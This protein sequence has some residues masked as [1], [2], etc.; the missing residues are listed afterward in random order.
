MAASPLPLLVALVLAAAA[1][2]PAAALEGYGNITNIKLTTADFPCN[3]ASRPP[4][5][6]FR[7]LSSAQTAMCTKKGNGWQMKIV[8]APLANVTGDMMLW[9]FRNLPTESAVSPLDNQTY[10]IYLLMHP[11]DH[12]KHTCPTCAGG[13]A[14]K[15][16]DNVTFAELPLTNCVRTAPNQTHPWVCDSA[17]DANPGV[18]QQNPAS[19]WDK[20]QQT[21]TT[22]RVV[23]LTN[24]KVT[25]WTRGCKTAS[26]PCAWIIK[27]T[28]SWKP[29]TLAGA[30]GLTVT[31][32]TRVGIGIGGPDKTI[33]DGYR[34]GLDAFTVC[35][36]NA[37][38]QVEEYGG[39]AEWLPDAYW[40]A[41]PPS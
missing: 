37:Q 21:G 2:S 39:L 16:G 5:W 29:S 11:R 30:P 4:L 32:D 41:N 12:A 1:I 24:K 10:P 15:A 22:V 25:W 23:A 20:F 8:H 7:L 38:H 6:P 9:L 17:P 40:R 13:R 28:Q 3:T 33:T 18:T 36:R 27:T 31:T 19:D 34:N 26:G 14:P 35:M